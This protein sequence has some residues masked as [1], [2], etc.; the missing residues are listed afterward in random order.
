MR[1]VTLVALLSALTVTTAQAQEA[2]TMEHATYTDGELGFVLQFRPGKS[3]EMGGMTSF[4]YELTTPDGKQLW[5]GIGTNMGTSRDVGSLFSG[6]ERPGP[7][8]GVL[9][10]AETESCRVWHDVVYALDDNRI[11][12]LPFSDE[13]APQSLVLADI[14]R[15]L[16]YSVLEGPGDEPWDQFFLTG[17]K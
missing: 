10:D 9:S 15:S 5:G 1:S 4:V 8:D 13:P 17:C 2:C 16:R 7:D 11:A 6:C 3:W 12:F 14:G